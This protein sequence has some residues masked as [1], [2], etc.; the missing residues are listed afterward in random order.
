MNT[1]NKYTL[2]LFNDNTVK[3]RNGW[4]KQMPKNYK[5]VEYYINDVNGVSYCHHRTSK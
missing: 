4:I 1:H 5:K 3:I 2:I